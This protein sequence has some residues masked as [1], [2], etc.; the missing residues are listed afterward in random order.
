MHNLRLQAHRPRQCATNFQRYQANFTNKSIPSFIFERVLLSVRF[1]KKHYPTDMI[2]RSSVIYQYT[3]D[4]C[5]LSY[6]GSTALQLFRRCALHR[7]ISFRTGTM[8]TRPDNSAIRDH[9]FNNEIPF[10]ISHFNVIDSTAQ[11]IL[12]FQNLFISIE[13]NND[14]Y[15]TATIVNILYIT[16]ILP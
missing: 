12:E 4:C 15:Q 6:I 5:Q 14:T 16:Y 3:C 13:I 1:F 11:K 2:V 8:L 9:C 10:K 7:G